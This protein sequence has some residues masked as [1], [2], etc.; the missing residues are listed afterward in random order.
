MTGSLFDWC[1]DAPQRPSPA[2]VTHQAPRQPE[3]LQNGAES[4]LT[5]SGEP[6]GGLTPRWWQDDALP[7]ILD[8]FSAVEAAED[9]ATSAGPAELVPLPRA[10]A[11]VVYAC[12][13]SG[14][15]VM[16]CE[17]VAHRVG[18]IGARDTL[19]VTVPTIA[20]VKQL[21]VDLRRRLATTTTASG[22]RP[23]VGAYYTDASEWSRSVVVT[24]HPS[25]RSMV[26]D[27]RN[28]GRRIVEWVA[29][30]CHRTDAEQVLLA[31]QDM[32]DAWGTVTRI[33]F[34]A[35]PYLS[36][37]DKGLR[38]WR[39]LLYSYT[40]DD[41][42]RDG[43]LVPWIRHGFTPAQAAR[44]ETAR[45]RY[46]AGEIDDRAID[47]ALDDACVEWVTSQAR[48]GGAGVVS[49]TSIADAEAFARV[50]SDALAAASLAPAYAVHS[51]QPAAVLAARRDA[52]ESG[53]AS[54]LVHVN[55]L[56]EGVDMPFL[57]WGALRR[58]RAR[59][60]F[61]QEVGRFLRVSAGKAFADIWDPLD[62]FA[63]HGLTHPAALADLPGRDPN[64]ER[65]AEGRVIEMMELVDPLTG[66]TY[67]VPLDPRLQSPDQQVAV[68]HS[69]GAAYIGDVA[70]C[71]RAASLIGAKPL[72]PGRWRNDPASERQ[73]E[74]M[75]KGAKAMRAITRAGIHGRAIAAAYRM[76]MAEHKA[77]TDAGKRTPIRKGAVS[78]FLDVLGA[79]RVT[80]NEESQTWD[81][82]RQDRAFAALDGVVDAEAVLAASETIAA[83]RRKVTR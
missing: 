13:G 61:V 54:A 41:A 75:V 53:R 76:I 77:A 48:L 57:R 45:A 16:L 55:M 23:S 36:D 73:I 79:V 82:T 17:I 40:P 71:L 59:V 22:H 37:P 6:W 28:G 31:W 81:T 47:A 44:Y 74:V 24:C 21:I 46:K 64:E 80:Y 66:R 19:L 34:S 27:C 4:A 18:R 14:K 60:G 20:L 63:E 11:G 39:H 51:K 83:A 3:A 70:S 69:A 43:A 10:H 5:P 8:A 2:Y 12:T 58:S 1:G 33:G 65:D 15:S 25:M 52:L 30:E 50:L 49:A 29:D 56:A 42:I 72:A 78:D 9:D 32:T 67:R 68:A 62:L 38:L 26:S 35:T 7:S